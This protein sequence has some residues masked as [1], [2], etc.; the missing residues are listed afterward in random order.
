[1]L[2]SIIPISADGVRAQ[3]LDIADLTAPVEIEKPAGPL[4]A[5]RPAGVVHSGRQV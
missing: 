1:M 2:A 3:G 5:L 4:M